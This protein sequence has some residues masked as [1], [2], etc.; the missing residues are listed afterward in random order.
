M[1]VE[2]NNMKSFEPSD[3]IKYLLKAFI[4]VFVLSHTFDIA[5]AIFDV[6]GHVVQSAVS[7]ISTSTAINL[8]DYSSMRTDLMNMEL[9][10]VVAMW[11]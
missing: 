11:A 1:V 7:V 8:G 9:Y 4:S 5:M 6:A 10:E 2:N 3:M